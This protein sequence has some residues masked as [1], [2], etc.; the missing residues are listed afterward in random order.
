M[1]TVCDDS[2]DDR[3]GGSVSSEQPWKLIQGQGVFLNSSVLWKPPSEV[4]RR[5]CMRMVID[6]LKGRP[7]AL[8]RRLWVWGST[9][10][11]H[12]LVRFPVVR[13]FFFL[14]SV[15]FLERNDRSFLLSRDHWCSVVA[16][17]QVMLF[18]GRCCCWRTGQR[19]RE[20]DR[21][22]VVSR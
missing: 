12:K 16:C 22:P 3:L 18:R 8:T 4:E 20:Y 7:R 10:M 17:T 19:L 9:G 13:F 21:L 5:L 15:I 6:R 1:V 11:A 2:D 14:H